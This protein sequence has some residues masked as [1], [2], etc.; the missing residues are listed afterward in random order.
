[1]ELL[2]SSL[3]PVIFS[4]KSTRSYRD[5]PVSEMML[6]KLR[7][8][9]AETVPL[10]SEEQAAFDIQ[11]HRGNTLK[12]AAYAES[13]A[14]SYM[15]LAFMLQQMDLFL[16]ANGLGALWNA[17]LRASEKQHLG[18]PYGICLVFGNA[19]KMPHRTGVSQFERK[20]PD[21]VAD[22]PGLSFVEAVR[23]APSAR[24]RQPWQLVCEEGRIDFYCRQGNFLD[25][26]LL[27]NLQWFDIGIAVCHAVLA[28]QNEGSLPAGTVKTGMPEKE[29][30]V[31]SISLEY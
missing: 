4:R 29:G 23:L 6:E 26:T 19:K 31:Y 2:N 18:L 15:N 1:M 16:Q 30:Y 28:L 14:S 13:E 10:I 17:T 21:E 11:P 24:N 7:A 25:R 22:R 3:Y 12:I 27:K 5:E 8:F 9:I 20:H